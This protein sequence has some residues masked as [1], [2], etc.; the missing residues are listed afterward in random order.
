MDLWLNAAQMGDP[1]K[2]PTGSASARTNG[3][4]LR[5]FSKTSID[6]LRTER[7]LLTP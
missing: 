1:G 3:R 4:D 6:E 7:F 2:R 5:R